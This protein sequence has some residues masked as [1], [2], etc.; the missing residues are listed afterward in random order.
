MQMV[1]VLGR[2]DTSA[3]QNNVLASLFDQFLL[4]SGDQGVV[5]S[6][7]T[8][9]TNYMHVVIDGLSGDFFG[10]LEETTHVNI[11]P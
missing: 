11:E 4:Q 3:D 8:G 10:G 9:S 5:T 6:S 1:V 7:Q 2:D